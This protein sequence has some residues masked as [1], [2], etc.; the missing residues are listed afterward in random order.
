METREAKL[1]GEGK[2]EGKADHPKIQT[3]LVMT[4]TYLVHDEKERVKGVY[5]TRAS[6][7]RRRTKAIWSTG[8]FT[9]TESGGPEFESRTQLVVTDCEL[10]RFEKCIFVLQS[11]K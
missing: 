4:T 1:K 6:A 9:C 8:T 5:E 3:Q 7:E 2:A 11:C 10:L